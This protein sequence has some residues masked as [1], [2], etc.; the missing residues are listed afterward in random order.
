MLELL[1]ELKISSSLTFYVLV[2]DAP[3][4]VDFERLIA[5]IDASYSIFFV[6][7]FLPDIIV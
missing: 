3:L 7:E 2:E 1:A 4:I 5:R 6:G